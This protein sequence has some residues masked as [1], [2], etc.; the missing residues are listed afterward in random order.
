M[1]T[2][3]K[4]LIRAKAHTNNGNAR[5]EGIW[6]TINHLQKIVEYFSI[7]GNDES[8]NGAKIDRV[9]FMI[10]KSI[11]N[12]NEFTVE[13]LPFGKNGDD[14]LLWEKNGKLG[15]L[16]IPGFPIENQIAP[17]DQINKL[18]AGGQKTPPPSL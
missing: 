2:D 7:P 10:G 17:D 11:T 15:F 12:P 16:D 14:F 3:S 18:I 8:E 1:A 9:A 13:V 5:N 6:L 4:A